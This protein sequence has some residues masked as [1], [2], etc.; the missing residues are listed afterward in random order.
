MDLIIAAVSGMI[1][2]IFVGVL[3]GVGPA[4]VLLTLFPLLSYFD[5]I[6]LFIFYFV[7][8][9]TS[10]YFG[11]VSAI[12]YG[13]A[14]EISSMPAVEHGHTLFRN[15]HGAQALAMTSTA[16]FFASCVGI[17]AMIIVYFNTDH[18]VW[19]Y[20]INVMVL[21]YVLIMI[22]I[23]VMTKKWL[24]SFVMM[25]LG[26]LLGKVG[27][28]A[29]HRV[30][31]LVPEYSFLDA[32]LPFYALFSGFLI[33]PLLFEY[34]KNPLKDSGVQNIQ[35]DP[36]STRFKNLFKFNQWTSVARGSILGGLIGLIPGASYMVSSNVCDRVEKYFRNNHLSRLI[37]AEAA[38][39]SAA[40][41]VLLPLLLFAVPIIPSEAIVLGLA[42]NLGFGTTVSLQFVKEHTLIIALILFLSNVTVWLLAGSFYKNVAKIYQSASSSIYYL[43]I[44]ATTALV[45]WI[46]YTE[47]QLLLSV[48]VFMFGL[49]LGW[50]IREIDSKFVLI[51][52]FFL[53]NTVLD[54]L[55]RFY[56]I[57]F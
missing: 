1:A 3:P 4:M 24:L 43:M 35:W 56:I 21:V 20:H 9:S 28:D 26:L 53:S 6:T 15:G 23:V 19:F 51:F 38:N 47:H 33:V 18:L 14:G 2:G 39:N 37:S 29:L 52:S 44:S 48:I 17:L 16:S 46:G 42:E 22:L 36:L 8:L 57:N 30:H 31:V 11:S 34:A 45:L 25:V 13:V 27:F 41:T 12:V 49:L 5:I 50:H 10:Q 55:Y 40:I 7:L 32:G 54:E